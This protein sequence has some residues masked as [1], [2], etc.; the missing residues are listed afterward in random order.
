[1]LKSE[2]DFNYISVNFTGIL[3]ETVDTGKLFVFL[4]FKKEIILVDNN[5]CETLKLEI[6][7]ECIHVI[8]CQSY[9]FNIWKTKK[10]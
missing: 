7:I 3:I 10:S 5:F 6:K 4:M 8:Y 2:K 1:M 9:K